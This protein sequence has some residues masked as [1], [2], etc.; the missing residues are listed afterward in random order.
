[1]LIFFIKKQTNF[2]LFLLSYFLIICNIYYI[3]YSKVI[4]PESILFSLVN[5]SIA[6]LF[7]EKKKDLI[8][9]G[10][11]CGF[12]AS[13]KPIG[14]AVSFV[15]IIA[16]S[17]KIKKYT[18]IIL[19]LISFAIPNI[20]EN[21]YFYKHFESRETV[22]NK[23][24]IGKLFILS[25][26]DSFN[27]NDYPEEL[28][29][30]LAI[31]KEEFKKVHVFLNNLDNILLKAELMS[32][33]EVVAQYQTF[34]LISVKKINFNKNLL[35]ADT[36]KIFFKIIS[37]N[38]YDY[39]KLS[40]YH[41]IGNWSIGSKAVY[42]AKQNEKIPHYY[43]LIKSSGKMNLPNLTLLNLAQLL[44]LFLFLLLTAYTLFAILCFLKIFKRKISHTD[45][46]VILLIQTYLLIISFTNVTTPRYLMLVY[47][48]IIFLC[49]RFIKLLNYN[50]K[51]E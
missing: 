15:L 39:I 17:I 42:L 51:R 8:I 35:F 34:N 9:F 31:T 18:K 3:S 38:F 10:L 6:Y 33:Y 25:G 28:K 7:R 12:I 22:I 21:L 11:I 27:I 30:L 45:F 32:D 5:L 23:S 20:I 36:K 49:M 2:I 14:L 19:L 41:Y 47:P 4:L 43:E 46:L 24:I 48:L 1:M 16:S 26:K 50:F 40:L 44:F 37:N 29:P 13:I